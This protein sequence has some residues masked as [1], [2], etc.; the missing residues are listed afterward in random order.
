M[1]IVCLQEAT[2]RMILFRQD[3]QITRAACLKT[4]LTNGCAIVSRRNAY[5]ATGLAVTRTSRS[6][7]YGPSSVRMENRG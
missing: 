5:G 7:H 6:L 3:G 2:M 1:I 4:T